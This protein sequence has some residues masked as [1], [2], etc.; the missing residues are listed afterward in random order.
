MTRR[1]ERVNSLLKEVI[2]EVILQDLKHCILP[3][4][5]TVTAVDTSRDLKHAKVYISLIE[6][7][8]QK[9]DE[10]LKTLQKHTAQIT[11]LASK[12][13]TMRYFPELLFKLDDSLDKYMHIDALLRQIENEKRDNG[14]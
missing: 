6:N 10:A 4:F 12:K 9:K 8:T 5:I 13:V 2:S 3:K 14:S 7:D 11:M 1:I